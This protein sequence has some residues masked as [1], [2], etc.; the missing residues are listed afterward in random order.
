MK[1]GL[2]I[3]LRWGAEHGIGLSSI[4][5]ITAMICF[6]FIFVSLHVF[7]HIGVNGLS[8]PGEVAGQEQV[9]GQS[10]GSSSDPSSNVIASSSAVSQGDTNGAAAS[11]NAPG[12]GN[13]ASGSVI[14]PDK[15][16]FVL[17]ISQGR[18]GS[19]LTGTMML[20]QHPA[21]GFYIDELVMVVSV[22]AIAGH[23]T[24]YTWELD[25]C[26]TC[27]HIYT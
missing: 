21:C 12:T 19:T 16:P 24:T 10:K 14:S 2:R 20:E 11:T 15:I 25:V 4:R 22:M 9:A 1:N 26:S 6:I 17:Q 18:S 7:L 27:T 23:D 5:M 8:V 13:G 3:L